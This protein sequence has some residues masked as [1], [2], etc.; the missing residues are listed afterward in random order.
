MALKNAALKINQF[1]GVS[2]SGNVLQLSGVDYP[3]EEYFNVPLNSVYR[4]TN[5]EEWLKI[6]NNDDTM[7]GWR[8]E[9]NPNIPLQLPDPLNSGRT[10]DI[11]APT[12]GSPYVGVWNWGE[13][14]PAIMVTMSA[15]V[16][17]TLYF[18]FYDAYDTPTGGSSP[19]STFPVIGFRYNGSGFNEF[20]QAVKGPRWYRV[21]FVPDDDSATTFRINSY[22]LDDLIQSNLPI[23][24]QVQSDQDATVVRAFISGF[25]PLGPSKIAPMDEHGALKVDIGGS[26]TQAGSHFVEGIRDDVGYKFSRDSGAEL[27]QLLV[28]ENS[29]NGGVVHDPVEGQAVFSVP[30]TSGSRCFFTTPDRVQYEPGHMIRSGM[31]I[32]PS[33]I[34]TDG[35]IRWGIGESDGA[36]LIQNA[37][38][39]GIDSSGLFVFRTKN[40]VEVYKEYQEDFELDNLSASELS[41]YTSGNTPIAFNPLMNSIY[42]QAFEWYGVAPP[43]FMIGTPRGKPLKVSIEETAGLQTGTTV[44]EPNL[45]LFVYINNGTTAEALTV[46]VGSMRGGINTSKITNSGRNTRGVNKELPIGDI[47]FTH[48]TVVPPLTSIDTGY[49]DVGRF[50]SSALLIKT[51]QDGTIRVYNSVDGTDANASVDTIQYV[52]ADLPEGFPYALPSTTGYIKFEFEN[53]SGLAQTY[54]VMQVKHALTSFQIPTIQFNAPVSDASPGALVRSGL[55]GKKDDGSTSYAN[56]Q[57]HESSGN[58][59]LAVGQGHRISQM[60]GR[61]HQE[62]A[63]T[64]VIV[65]GVLQAITPGFIFWAHSMQITGTNS[66]TANPGRIRIRDGTILGPIRGSLTIKEASSGLGA[67]AE[68]DS[69]SIAF[70]EP[71]QF[72]TAIYAEIASGTLD[73]DIVL[74]GYLEPV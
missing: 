15:D 50:V 33:A 72:S 9:V 34:P 62:Y 12:T 40:Q 74:S 73:V 26:L 25:T 13:Y 64:N 41:E 67:P 6:T 10:P 46:R 18:D 11:T 69:I 54:F 22:L 30:A 29:I 31:T 71:T 60:F 55:L 14:L 51:D 32:Q 68:A 16:A 35:E 19:T 43:T 20:H 52:S 28:D 70:P 24:Q 37:I 1:A 5:G 7:A 23:N 38:G 4:R 17:G 63:F 3:W 66:S 47:D 2:I 48:T 53:S 65:G 56:V 49:V 36:G 8:L 42:E 57:V 59:S 58:V 39:W 21:R 45:P 61:S 27:V 44:P